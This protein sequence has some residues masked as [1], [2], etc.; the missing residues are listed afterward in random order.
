MPLHDSIHFSDDTHIY[1]W[2][3][4]E[5]TATLIEHCRKLC[6]P[7][8]C[9]AG[10]CEKRLKEK[11]VELLLLRHI[12]GSKVVLQHSPTGAPTIGTQCHISVSHSNEWVGIA[13]NYDHSIGIDIEQW[14]SRVL[15]VR[16][17]FLSN[18]EFA[19]ISADDVNANLLAWT[20]KEALYK[21]F[22]GKGGASLTDNYAIEAVTMQDDLFMRN[23]HASCAPDK[24]L[25]VISTYL[26]QK[27]VI[28][29]AVET[30][31]IK[32]YEQ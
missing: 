32:L 11:L 17:R 6:L 12:F 19:T 13:V 31:Y 1:L 8:P 26:L 29:L 7:L 14:N 28:S 4:I 5:N 24:S 9:D 15:R 27:A 30:K 2:Q 18:F 3:L 16:D 20:A 23:A 10:C 21:L 22:D 25:T